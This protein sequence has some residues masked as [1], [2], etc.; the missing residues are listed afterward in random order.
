MTML[1]EVLEFIK[2]DGLS[3]NEA[4]CTITGILIATFHPEWAQALRASF[5]SERNLL[6]IETCA[7]LLFLNVPIND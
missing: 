6:N 1:E 2:N 7:D 3:D 5:Q 4:K